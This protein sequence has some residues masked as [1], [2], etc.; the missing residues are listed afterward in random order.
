MKFKNLKYIWIDL[1]SNQKC[2]LL[3]KLLKARFTST[4]FNRSI[5]ILEIQ[6]VTLH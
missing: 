3:L 6:N 5:T 4:F 1:K 2:I